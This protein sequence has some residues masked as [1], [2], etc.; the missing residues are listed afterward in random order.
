MSLDGGRKP[1]YPEGN[2]TNAGQTNKLHTERPQTGVEAGTFL[3][4]GNICCF[5]VTS[6]GQGSFRIIQD[7]NIVTKH[8]EQILLGVKT[9]TV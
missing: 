4:W 5:G 1:A 7:L 8:M 2:H 3:L 9:Q 6:Y